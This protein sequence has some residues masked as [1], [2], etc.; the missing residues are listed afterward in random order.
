M[1]S[2]LPRSPDET[3]TPVLVF[4]AGRH[5][6]A[7]TVASVECVVDVVAIEP[8]P[9][10]PAAVPGIINFHGSVV[11]VVDPRLRFGEQ[12]SELN[13]TQKLII[14]ETPKRRVALLADGADDVQWISGDEV[15]AF[16]DFVPGLDMPAA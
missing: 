6:C 9:G 13:C 1:H 16:E 10:A 4:R 2:P 12:S 5:R 8:V 7:I 11:P 14:V 3:R 15:S